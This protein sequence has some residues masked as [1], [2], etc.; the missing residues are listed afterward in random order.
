MCGHVRVHN[1]LH[2]SS[3]DALGSTCSC[4]VDKSGAHKTDAPLPLAQGPKVGILGAAV[5]T[6][7]AERKIES[8]S[9]VL[10]L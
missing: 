3:G 9:A 5:I 1:P 6:Q 8:P 4:K 2:Q 10:R 7:S